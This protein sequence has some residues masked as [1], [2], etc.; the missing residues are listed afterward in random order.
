MDVMTQWLILFGVS[1]FVLGFAGTRLAK[2]HGLMS[3]RG[4]KVMADWQPSKSLNFFMGYSFSPLT[5]LASPVGLYVLLGWFRKENDPVLRRAGRDC[6][7]ALLFG[8][9]SVLIAVVYLI[10][11]ATNL[12]HT[13]H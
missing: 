2:L 4:S 7:I 9:F 11:I 10:Y 3:S 6:L 12:P 8:L 13:A 5:Y 1:I